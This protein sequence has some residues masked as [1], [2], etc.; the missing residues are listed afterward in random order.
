MKIFLRYLLDGFIV[1]IA[2]LLMT[3]ILNSMHVLALYDGQVKLTRVPGGMRAE[4]ADMVNA[5]KMN[6]AIGFFASFVTALVG[7]ILICGKIWGRTLGA[8]LF[9]SQNPK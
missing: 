6:L 2:A 9:I 7:Y 1:L 4:Y 8:K 5:L 3:Q